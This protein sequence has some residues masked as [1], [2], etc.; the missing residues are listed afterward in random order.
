ME[1]LYFEFVNTRIG[2]PFRLLPFGTITKNGRSQEVTPETAALFKLPHFKPPIKLGSHA[3]TTPAGGHIVGLEVRADGLYAIPEWNDNGTAA[4]MAGGFR[5]HSPEI[6]WAGEI[7]DSSTGK[8]T[9]GPIILGDALLHTPALGEAAAFYQVNNHGGLETMAEN[10]VQ[11]PA[12]IWERIM[13]AFTSGHNNPDPAPDPTPPPTDNYA[14]ELAE[15]NNRVE[16]LTAQTA[17]YQAEIQ[18]LQAER[19]AAQQ[20]AHYS[21]QLAETAVNEDTELITLLARLD[22]ADANL[23]VQRF[24]A[25]SAQIGTDLET[26]A[27]HSGDGRNDPAAVLQTAVEQYQAD[28]PGAT[29]NDAIKVLTATKPELFK[30]VI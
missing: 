4:M 16:Q 13:D 10:T 17:E 21:A 28:N 27:G 18:R 15:A 3:D 22:E 23:L 2:E 8:K 7:E 11:V 20:V 19:D 12:G 1:H 26:E 5:Y 29:Y 14:V 24:S 25:L 6:L 9:S 30:G